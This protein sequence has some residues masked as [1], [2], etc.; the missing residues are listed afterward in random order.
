[1]YSSFKNCDYLDSLARV[2]MTD[3]QILLYYLQQTEGHT[4][5]HDSCFVLSDLC[6]WFLKYIYTKTSAS[7]DF[8]IC[9]LKQHYKS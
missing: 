8:F 6:K 2:C 1:M 7:P 5:L 4:V 9:V 3:R